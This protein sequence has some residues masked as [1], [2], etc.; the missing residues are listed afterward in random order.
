MNLKEVNDHKIIDIIDHTT[1]YN[2]VSIAKS[3]SKEELLCTIFQ[4]RIPFL[5]APNQIL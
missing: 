1:Q 5:A 3:K 4:H 2:A